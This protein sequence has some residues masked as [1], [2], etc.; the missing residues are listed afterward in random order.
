[1]EI[2]GLPIT[3]TTMLGAL[4]KVTGLM[5]KRALETPLKRRFGKIAEKN[6]RAY[7]TAYEKTTILE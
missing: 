1:M 6:I 2:L 5:E 4:V 3:N 7:E